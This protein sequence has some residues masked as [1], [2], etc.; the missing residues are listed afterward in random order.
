MKRSTNE[1]C[2]VFTAWP[3]ST[4]ER[5]K[6]RSLQTDSAR[7]FTWSDQGAFGATKAVL[8]SAELRLEGSKA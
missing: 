3:V 6:P 2:A 7:A 5:R 4:T 8:R 1:W